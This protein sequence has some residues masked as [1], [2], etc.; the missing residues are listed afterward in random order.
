M[1]GNIHVHIDGIIINGDAAAAAAASALNDA[2][3]M[4]MMRQMTRNHNNMFV[5]YISLIRFSFIQRLEY[6]NPHHD[7]IRI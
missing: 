5:T 6:Y 7:I 3:L 1:T 4:M 2:M